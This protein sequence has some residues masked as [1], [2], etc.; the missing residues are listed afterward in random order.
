MH[1]SERVTRITASQTLAITKRVLE[2]KRGGENVI[3]L[4]AGEPDFDT[5]AHIR[6]AAIDAINK[7][8]TRYTQPTGIPELKEA[9]VARFQKQNGIESKPE[10]VI[11][12]CGGKHV[13]S[14]AMLSICEKGDEVVIWSPYWVSYPAMVRLAEAE[15]V[16]ISTRA[17]EQFSLDLE[18]LSGAITPN[19][20]AIIFCNPV[21]PTGAVY[22]PEQTDA[23]VDVL[24]ATDAMIIADELYDNM[25][26]D[27][28]QV[29]SLGSYSALKGRVITVNGV[30]KAYAMTGW[31][32]GY[33][34]GPEE[35]ISQMAKIQ[36]HMTSNPTSIS[37]WAAL[38]ALTGPQDCVKTMVRTFKER[39][40]FVFDRLNEIEGIV[41]QPCHGA[42][43]LFPDISAFFGRS[44]ENFKIGSSVDFCTYLLESAKVALVPGEAFGSPNHVRISFATSLELL[45]EAMDRIQNALTRLNGSNY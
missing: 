4:G 33:A 31:R 5:P 3:G 42:F 21:N 43:Y 14:T 16:I 23:L 20:R 35:H 15:P 2:L 32:I 10:N 27:N 1:F 41:C 37:Q 7:G 24:S 44:S 18:E 36:S 29:R 13:L 22:G 30:S 28:V 8:Y 11:V 40:D 17:N 34:V 45:G 38:A 9:I 6:E 25:L 26:Y 19:T 39:R 12:S